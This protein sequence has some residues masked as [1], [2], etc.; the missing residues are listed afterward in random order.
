MI[1]TI[2]VTHHDRFAE[3]GFR[4]GWEAL[5]MTSQQLLAWCNARSGIIQRFE[6]RLPTRLWRS[7]IQVSCSLTG[8]M[9]GMAIPSFTDRC[10]SLWIHS[11]CVRRIHTQAHDQLAGIRQVAPHDP[12]RR[13]GYK[14]L[15]ADQA[16][17]PSKI[18]CRCG[19]APC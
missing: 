17:R 1:D 2:I 7:L 12:V 6:G 11:L 3:L 16:R 15:P 13:V 4:P 8:T 5:Q 14:Y 9:H 19:S 10:H 18:I